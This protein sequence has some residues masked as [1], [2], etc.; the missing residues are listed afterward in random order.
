ML[1]TMEGEEELEKMMSRLSRFF[2]NIFD[3]SLYL[4]A[5]LLRTK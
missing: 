4:S 2:W 5:E 1:S 3:D